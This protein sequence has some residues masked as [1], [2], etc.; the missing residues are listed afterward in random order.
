MDEI[1]LGL[2]LSIVPVLQHV[3]HDANDLRNL[4]LTLPDEIGDREAG[5]SSNAGS[6][7]LAKEF[8]VHDRRQVASAGIGLP[9]EPSVA[10]PKTDRAPLRSRELSNRQVRV[11][12]SASLR[13]AIPAARRT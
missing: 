5:H 11:R 3:P 8:L 10:Q 1:E 12:A 9:E 13:S 2:W 7:V 4:P 6:Q